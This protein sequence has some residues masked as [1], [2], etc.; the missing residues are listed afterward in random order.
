MLNKRVFWIRFVVLSMIIA[1]FSVPAFAQDVYVDFVPTGAWGD[2]KYVSG[3][4]F[5]PIPPEVWPPGTEAEPR[6]SFNATVATSAGTDYCT[7]TP[8][9][10]GSFEI[11]VS[12]PV[13]AA[14]QSQD[15][16]IDIDG[17]GTAEFN[18][19]VFRSTDAAGNPA[20]YQSWS[21]WYSIG[22]FYLTTSSV[23]T[24]DRYAADNPII[25]EP[26]KLVRLRIVQH[27][28]PL[29]PVEAGIPTMRTCC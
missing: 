12:W 25:A 17:D 3:G 24:V 11:F 18:N 23:I 9:L 29:H 21:G 15:Y 13:I 22:A 1:T 27:T 2:W 14:A 20:V 10:D 19:I 28:T 5:D 6:F 4:A 16:E 8:G 26:L 7:W